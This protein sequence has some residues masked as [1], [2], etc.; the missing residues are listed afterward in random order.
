[1]SDAPGKD[2]GSLPLALLL[3]VDEVCLRFEAAWRAGEQPCIKDYLEGK[4]EPEYSLLLRQLLLL[5]L[6]YRDRREPPLLEEY[7][8]VLRRREASGMIAHAPLPSVPG[9]EVLGE[10]GRG[11]MGVVYKARQLGLNRLVA[12]KMISAAESA[13]PEQALRFRPEAEAIARL[14]HPNIVQI[15]EVGEREGRPYFSLEYV[16]GGTLAKRLA[17]APLPPCEAAQMATTLAAAMDAAHQKGVVHRDLKPANVLLAGGPETPLPRCFLKIADFGLAKQLDGE[18]GQTHTGAILGT[19]S[20]MAPEQAEGRVKDVGPATDVYALGAIL[21]EMLTGRAPFKGTT[22]LETLEQVRRQEPVPPRQINPALECN[23]EAICL[24]CLRKDQ[25]QRYATA[26]ALAEDL[27]RFLNHEPT[28]ARP[29]VGMHPA[30]PETL[31]ALQQPS[32]A[33]ETLPRGWRG[34]GVA[35]ALAAVL[36]PLAVGGVLLLPTP[37]GTVGRGTRADEPPKMLALDLGDTL[38]LEL[39]LI[40]EGRFRMGPS[41]SEQEQYFKLAPSAVRDGDEH[42]VE[43]TRLFYLGK[44]EVTQGQYTRVTGKDNPSYFCAAGD[45]RD[46]VAGLDTGRFP[47]EGVSWDDAVAFCAALQHKCGAQVP[48]ALRQAG[49]RFRLPTEAQWEYACRAGTRATFHFGDTLNGTQANCNGEFPWGTAAK[50]P[51]LGRTER[52]GS[53]PANDWGICDMHGNVWEWCQDDYAADYYQTGPRQDPVNRKAADPESRVLR[54]GSWYD[55][56][57]ECRAARRFRRGGGERN[58]T[59]GFRVA[60]RADE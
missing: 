14:Q 53:Y 39:L 49:Y 1:M 44:F 42:P 59:V 48:E 26:A 23:L 29:A 41:R 25:R 60:L 36:V 18:S 43:I 58:Y 17:G 22:P 12:L 46:K 56:A 37:S 33:A 15:Y 2:P 5:E 50:G 35:A 28:A 16:E 47:V 32:R 8:A 6:E 3:R 10:L 51:Y 55:T 4:A 13:G 38:K 9:Y 30:P 24:K 34:V 54:G 27:R 21:Y 52:V 45:G 57:Q 11:G 20:Y 19:P 40:G 7:R 31:A